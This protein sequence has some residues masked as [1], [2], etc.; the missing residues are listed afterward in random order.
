MNLFTRIAAVRTLKSITY[1]TTCFFSFLNIK[2][3]WS[4]ITQYLFLKDE[5]HNQLEL[6]FTSKNPDFCDRGVF[7]ISERSL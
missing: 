3:A 4:L 7:S 6:H 2:I 5:N 1:S